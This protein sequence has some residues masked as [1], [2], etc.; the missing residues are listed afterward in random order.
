M[1]SFIHYK[2]NIGYMCEILKQIFISVNF[3]KIFQF[4]YMLNKYDVLTNQYPI[5]LVWFDYDMQE[6]NN[7]LKCL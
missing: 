6:T 1:I 7:G 4:N 2:N 5:I 3:C